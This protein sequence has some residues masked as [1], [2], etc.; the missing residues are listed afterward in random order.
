MTKATKEKSK[1]QGCS[2]IL[3]HR[4]H[5]IDDQLVCCCG[6]TR[7]EIFREKVARKVH[8][9]SASRRRRVAV[10]KQGYKSRIGF[11]TRPLRK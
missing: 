1:S 9:R 7:F 8:T 11:P 6:C 2:G 10:C 4:A 5:W 3:Q